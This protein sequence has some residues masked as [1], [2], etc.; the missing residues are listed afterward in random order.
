M[1][2]RHHQMLGLILWNT[3]V[4]DAG[5]PGLG[6]PYCKVLS[7]Q[8]MNT[9]LMRTLISHVFTKIWQHES[10]QPVKNPSCMIHST[11]QNI[12]RMHAAD[13]NMSRMQEHETTRRETEHTWTEERMARANTFTQQFTIYTELSWMMPSLN[14]IMKCLKIYYFAILCRCFVTIC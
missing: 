10:T 4:G 6:Y 9:Q 2:H 12:I 13:I 14:S 7:K 5:H 8:G 3:V 1:T 11:R